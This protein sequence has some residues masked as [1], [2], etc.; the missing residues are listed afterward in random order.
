[1]GLKAPPS[2]VISQSFPTLKLLPPSCISSRLGDPVP[3]CSIFY[4]ILLNLS[5]ARDM[6]PSLK[7]SFLLETTIFRGELLVLVK[8]NIFIQQSITNHQSE[9]ISDIS[10]SSAEK[11]SSHPSLS[12]LHHLSAIT[13]MQICRETRNVGQKNHP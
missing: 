11:N 4:S 8:I 6:V 10:P 7:L 3:D 5:G 9:G 1:M 13:T 2:L 12:T